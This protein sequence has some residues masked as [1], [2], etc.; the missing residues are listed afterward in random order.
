MVKPIV[1]DM[2]FLGQK[3]ET[4]TKADAQVAIDLKDTL[5]AHR[6]GCVGM[7]ANMIGYKKRTIIV[8]MGI[9][10]LVMNNPVIISKS[11]EYEAEEGCLSL[12]GTRKT[13]RYRDIEVEYEDT[14]FKKQKQKFTGF[15]AQIVQHEMDH[16]EGIII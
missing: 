14:S 7:A 2:F 10:D 6:A 3:S 4:A 11:G 12:E 16:L 15:P 5:A 9:V 8:S 1:R 13:T